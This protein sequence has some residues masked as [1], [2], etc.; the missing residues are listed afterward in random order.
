M[1]NRKLILLVVLAIS[2]TLAFSQEI[3]NDSIITQ[4][5]PSGQVKSISI[6]NDTI[7]NGIQLEI[8]SNGRLLKQEEY[9]SG[10]LNGKQITFE[11]GRISLVKN[12][13]N[14]LLDGPVERFTNSRRLSS[15]ENFSKGIKSGESTWYYYSGKLCATYNYE[16]GSIV[17]ESKFYHENG[18]EKSVYIFSKNEINGPYIE[19][20]EEGKTVVEGQYKKGKKEGK[21]KYYDATGKIKETV[22]YKKGVKK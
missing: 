16:N 10:V 6:L 13:K 22:K 3:K 15:S 12:Y 19:Y 7:K 2:S 20:D 1:L 4:F 21:W 14:G 5:F 8:D 11:R 17:G 9:I 18:K